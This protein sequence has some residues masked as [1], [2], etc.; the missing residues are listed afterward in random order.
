MW[1]EHNTR[2]YFSMIDILLYSGIYSRHWTSSNELL[3]SNKG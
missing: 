1:S 2:G 3:A